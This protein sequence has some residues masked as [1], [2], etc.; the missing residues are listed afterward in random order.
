MNF[1]KIILQRFSLSFNSF[2]MTLTSG[3]LK[4]V[5]VMSYDGSGKIWQNVQE[6]QMHLIINTIVTSQ[7]YD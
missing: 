1:S 7:S 5:F 6:L 3:Y 2:E 4:K